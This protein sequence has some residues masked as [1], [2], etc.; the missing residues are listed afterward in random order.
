M[1]AGALFRSVE[2]RRKSAAIALS[3]G[4]SELGP[5]HPVSSADGCGPSA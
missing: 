1:R 2:K 4:T 5:Q 3:G